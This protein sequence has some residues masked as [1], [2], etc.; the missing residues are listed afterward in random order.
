VDNGGNKKMLE[1]LQMFL[2]LFKSK[3]RRK[4]HLWQAVCC[5]VLVLN[6]CS[7][8]RAKCSD[9]SCSGNGVC[10]NETCVCYDGWQGPQCQFCGGKV[11]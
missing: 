2:F 7:L 10:K 4:C 6:V 5:A 9:T 8:V 3:Y 1:I 11:R